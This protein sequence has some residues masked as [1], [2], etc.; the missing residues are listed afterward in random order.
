[1][2]VQADSL[3]INEVDFKVGLKLVLIFTLQFL[4]R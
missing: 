1:M 2:R 4:A 3:R